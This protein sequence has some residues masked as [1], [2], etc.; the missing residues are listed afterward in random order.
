MYVS[1]RM[2]PI[3][4]ASRMLTGF[5]LAGRGQRFGCAASRWAPG[6]ACRPGR[7][8]VDV[9]RLGD[10]PGGRRVIGLDRERDVHVVVTFTSADRQAR[11]P[12]AV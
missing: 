4:L 11:R 8:I 9:D 7:L 2:T 10:D 12:G 3:N 5:P 6:G 1:P